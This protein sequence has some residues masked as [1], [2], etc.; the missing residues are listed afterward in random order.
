M[1]D[2]DLLLFCFADICGRNIYYS[3]DDR[4]F[5]IC[6]T[7]SQVEENAEKTRAQRA[8]RTRGD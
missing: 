3:D 8:T 4:T 5:S 7:N 2:R 1:S 6:L